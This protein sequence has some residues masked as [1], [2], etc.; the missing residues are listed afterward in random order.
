MRTSI[1]CVNHQ[2]KHSSNVF[3]LVPCRRRK[4]LSRTSWVSK[5]SEPLSR[6][7]YWLD[8]TVLSRTRA[9]W[10][11]TFNWLFE[12]MPT[13]SI[14]PGPDSFSKVHPRTSV[15]DQDELASL[16]Q[17]PIMAGTV[18]RGSDVIG[19]GELLLLKCTF[20]T[21]QRNNVMLMQVWSQTTGLHFVDWTRHRLSCL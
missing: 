12:M 10:Y 1:G 14:F 2:Y 15:E 20:C 16:L 9:D 13:L 7:M 17:I 3:G 8:L 21:G 4:K 18:N 6:T 19:A 5:C 11:A